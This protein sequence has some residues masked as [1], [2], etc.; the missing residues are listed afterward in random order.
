MKTIFS[1]C[2]AVAAIL[3]SVQDAKADKCKVTT[4]VTYQRHDNGGGMPGDCPFM[5]SGC[6][7][8]VTTVKEV[9]CIVTPNPSGG[10]TLNVS[11]LDNVTAQVIRNDEPYV[12]IPETKTVTFPP[13]TQFMIT[14]SNN[15]AFV[16]KLID[17][18]GITTD[19][20][21]GFTANFN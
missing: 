18:S 17:V 14:S 5:G 19:S 16:G 9:D 2:L 8:T 11:S 21:G 12:F 20:N 13:N 4:T 1:I 10:W 7:V 3:F 15:P 6:T